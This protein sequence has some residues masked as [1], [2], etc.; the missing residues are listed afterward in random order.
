MR[1]LALLG[2]TTTGLRPQPTRQELLRGAAASALAPVPPARAEEFK[3]VAT[4]RTTAQALG[5]DERD[6]PRKNQDVK[7]RTYVDPLFDL[8]F[9]KDWFA[10]R[11]T[12]DGDIVRRGGVIF[13]AGNLRTAE[14]VTVELFKVKELLAQAEALPYFPEGKIKQWN[15]LGKDAALAQF[16]CERRDGEA[17]ASARKQQIQARASTAVPGSLSVR[18]DV[19]QLDI[20]TDIQGTTARVGEAGSEVM[21]PGIRR[22]Q[23]ARLTLLPGG[24]EVMGVVAG[25]LDDLWSSGEDRVLGDV[26]ESFRIKAAGA[27]PLLP[28]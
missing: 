13:S 5:V 1:L 9:P 14:V 22:L 12:I 17:T 28:A 26:V 11:R 7:L 16:V 3:D 23:R 19:L 21:T 2:L 25:C 8:T 15:D 27:A 10:I 24:S 20:A 6:L 4:V 18:G